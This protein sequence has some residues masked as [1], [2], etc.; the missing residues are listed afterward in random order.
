MNGQ[1]AKLNSN[2]ANPNANP[3]NAA[4][5]RPPTQ[6]PRPQQ[7]NSVPPPTDPRTQWELDAESRRLSQQVE[8]ESRERRRKEKEA[9]R[10]TQK[11]LQAEEKEARKRQA[12]IDKETERLK[13][14]YGQEDNV[15][16]QRQKAPQ[17]PPRPQQPPQINTHQRYPSHPVPQSLQSRPSPVMTGGLMP[18]QPKMKEKRSIFGLRKKEGESSQNLLKKRSSMF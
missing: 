7:T 5:T 15:S 4:P 17:V 9:D 11:L 3:Q 18:P 16:R 2:Q 10:R 13:R 12:Q 6:P 14:L 8:A 1:N